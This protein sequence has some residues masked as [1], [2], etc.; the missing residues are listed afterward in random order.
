MRSDVIINISE[1][2]EKCMLSIHDSFRCQSVKLPGLPVAI[3]VLILSP[4]I[5]FTSA[6]YATLV[7]LIQAKSSSFPPDETHIPTFYVPEHRYS[8]RYHILLLLSLGI[9]F[10][11]IH[12]F[13]WN[14]SFPTE[15]EQKLWRIASLAVTIIPIATFPFVFIIT[16]MEECLPSAFVYHYGQ[17]TFILCTLAYVSAR[18]V[19][20]GLAL[21][22]LR[23]LPP[24]A[25]IA[26]SWTKFFPH[27]L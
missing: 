13:G 20:L 6:F 1:F 21:A 25:S 8:K 3:L 17:S 4:I 2:F 24:T 26:I 22:L 12:C 9:L 27:F 11:G 16:C 14:F 19:L 7:D 15:V 10:G 18:L 23:L 5:T